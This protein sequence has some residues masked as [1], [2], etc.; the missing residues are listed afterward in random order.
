MNP[1]ELLVR[2]VNYL[3]GGYGDDWTIPK[4][5]QDLVDKHFTAGETKM[6]CDLSIERLANGDFFRFT[7]KSGDTVLKTTDSKMCIGDVTQ[8]DNLAIT[9][10]GDKN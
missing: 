3:T 9:L 7:F 4:E 5:G 8:L 10:Y 1:V 6:N 2:A